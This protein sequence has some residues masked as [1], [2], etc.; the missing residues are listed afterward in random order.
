MSDTSTPRLYLVSTGIGEPYNITLRAR[1]IISRADLIVG[2]PGQCERL[3]NLLDG[4]EIL[5][6]GHGLFTELALRHKDAEEVAQQEQHVRERIRTAWQQCKTIAIIEMGDP[7][8]FGPQVGYLQEFADLNPEVIPGIS[9]FNAANALLAR[10]LLQGKAGRLQLSGLQALDAAS[11]DCLP[12]TW[13][14]FSMGLDMPVVIER[15]QQLYP[16]DT[17]IALVLEAGFANQ[18]SIEA[19]LGQLAARLATEELPWAC[20]IYIG[21]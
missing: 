14:L 2:L 5:D 12:D 9:S 16:A 6:A 3:G 21:V 18:R 13:V 19:P 20:L 4:K 1:R 8:L 11:K 10:P 7:C 17:G 15:L